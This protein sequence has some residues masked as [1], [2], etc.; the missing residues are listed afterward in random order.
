[1]LRD[2]S[3]AEEVLHEVFVEAFRAAHGYEQARGTVRA[4][5]ATRMRSRALDRIKSHG[6]SRAVDIEA[7]G[8]VPA[9]DDGGAATGDEARLR[10]ALDTLPVD[11]RAVIELAYFDG[12]SSSEIASRL[13]IPVGTVKSRTAAAFGK[14]RGLLGAS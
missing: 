13:A 9:R 14:L 10:G 11:Q 4:W 5:L 7:V 1:M 2:A 6:R 8:E 3:E 12:L